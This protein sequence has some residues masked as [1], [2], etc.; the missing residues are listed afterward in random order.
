MIVRA[1]EP[2]D[3][4]Q[5]AA[6]WNPIIRDTDLTFTSDEKRIED[7][8]GSIREKARSGQGF[9]VAQE[10]DAVV[11]FA[12]YGMFRSGP[13]YI[14]CVEHSI[15]LLPS[16]QGRGGGRALMVRLMDHA[17]TQGIHTMIA[18]IAGHNEAAIAFHSRIGFSPVAHLK[19]VGYKFGRRLDLVLMQQLL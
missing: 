11:G 9:V 3:A 13:G 7:I 18:G 17:K 2:G 8:A 10:T 14:H 19:E 16:A 15:Y 4:A 12:S 6:I 1:A 5:I